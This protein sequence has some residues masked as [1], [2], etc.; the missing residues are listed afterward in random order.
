MP[1]F[2]SG[3]KCR[4]GTEAGDRFLC[5]L[6]ASPP[7]RPFVPT[8]PGQAPAQP[9]RW[10]ER[11]RLRGTTPS[12]RQVLAQGRRDQ[13]SRNQRPDLRTPSPGPDPGRTKGLLVRASR[14]GPTRGALVGGGG[15]RGPMRRPRC[16]RQKRA[17]AA[18]CLRRSRAVPVVT[19]SVA[20]RP[21]GS[22][23]TSRASRLGPLPSRLS[24]RDQSDLLPRTAAAR[25]RRHERSR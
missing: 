21:R 7:S 5:A 10:L 1:T 23:R 15:G 14:G 20:R 6:G 18:R 24:R 16:R 3:P 9:P 4:C 25:P 22:G 11:Q 8:T 19:A 17:Q 2:P 13:N 12:G